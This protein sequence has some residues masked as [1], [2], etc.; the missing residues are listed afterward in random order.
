MFD[1]VT[2]STKW[3]RFPLDLIVLYSLKQNNTSGSFFPGKYSYLKQGI[4]FNK[5]ILNQNVW[6]FA[7]NV[8]KTNSEKFSCTE[9]LIQC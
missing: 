6:L 7:L 8:P 4:I 2:W 9:R 3:R 1:L 5:L